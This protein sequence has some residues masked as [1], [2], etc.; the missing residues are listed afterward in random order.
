M[1][2]KGFTL[3]E[4]LITLAIIGVVAALTLPSLVSDTASAQIGPKLGKAVSMF[5]QANEAMLSDN[6]V[7]S[8]EDMGVVQNGE[9]AY[10]SELSNHLKSTANGQTLTTKDNVSYNITIANNAGAGTVPH[11]RY[12]GTVEIDI[13]ASN[14]QA[15]PG[16]DAFLFGLFDDGSL[17]PRGSADWDGSG[18]AATWQANCPVDAAPTVAED[19]AAHIFANNMKVRYR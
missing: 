18:G 19:C 11:R 1:K 6:S 7:D 3:S 16:E 15:T 17:R 4:V 12:R 8:L 2:R 5:E 9:A 10:T 14:N 13:N